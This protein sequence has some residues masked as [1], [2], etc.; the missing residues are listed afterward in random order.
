MSY[1][2]G[3]EHELKNGRFFMIN[4]L[5]SQFSLAFVSLISFVT[6]ILPATS[7]ALV[8]E[9]ALCSTMNGQLQVSIFDNQGIG[10]KRESQINAVITDQNGNTLATYKTEI[11]NTI[12]S[13]SFGRPTFQ[14]V[15]TAGAAFSLA[16]PSTNFH[17]YI[18]HA[19]IQ[20][21]VISDSQMKCSV[22]GNL[23]SQ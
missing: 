23:I 20:G 17:N 22:F 11:K 10:L 1:A 12:R 2:F 3:P 8:R 6:F 21:R 16:G 7:H 15:E 19:Q 5:K 13:A 14:D 18:L 4:N 9:L